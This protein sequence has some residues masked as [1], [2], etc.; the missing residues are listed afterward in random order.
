M[1]GWLAG[2]LCR[3]HLYQSLAS[4]EAPSAHSIVFDTNQGDSLVF[5]LKDPCGQELNDA[6]KAAWPQAAYYSLHVHVMSIA[7]CVLI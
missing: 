2:W 5:S 1:A 4:W 3:T 7:A 6:V